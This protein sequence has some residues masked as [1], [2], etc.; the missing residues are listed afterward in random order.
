MS[1]KFSTLC[2]NSDF[3]RP[4]PFSVKRNK[5]WKNVIFEIFPFGKY[6][7][8][9]KTIKKSASPIKSYQSWFQDQFKTF[10]IHGMFLMHFKIRSNISCNI[11]IL[12]DPLLPQYNAIFL[13][14]FCCRLPF[15][16]E[17]H[18]SRGPVK[19]FQKRWIE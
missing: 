2:K 16:F 3:R 4:T 19:T 7:F 10:L 15:L 5:S 17:T 11:G 9:W 14:N 8:I 1:R 6:I 12:I 13:Q 18:A